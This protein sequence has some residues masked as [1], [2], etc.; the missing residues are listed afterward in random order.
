MTRIC[1]ATPKAGAQATL[2]DGTVKIVATCN[3]REKHFYEEAR[4]MPAIYFILTIGSTLNIHV[5]S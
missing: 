4:K 3:T 5:I 2:Q 1:W